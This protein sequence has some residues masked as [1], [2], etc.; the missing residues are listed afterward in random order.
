MEAWDRDMF[1]SVVAR[2][3]DD[4]HFYSFLHLQYGKEY[5]QVDIQNMGAN[6]SQESEREENT[7][8]KFD[9]VYQ[10]MM[11]KLDYIANE[12]ERLIMLH[13]QITTEE[14]PDPDSDDDYSSSEE[15]P[16]SDSDDDSTDSEDDDDYEDDN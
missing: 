10:D 7:D 8:I 12:V 9:Q 2:I 3:I 1:Q 14:D 5:R 6:S 16:D 13:K 4:L 11:E 15:E